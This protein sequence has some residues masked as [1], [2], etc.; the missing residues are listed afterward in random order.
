MHLTPVKLR[1]LYLHYISSI[2]KELKMKTMMKWLASLGVVTTLYAQPVMNNPFNDPFFQDP[3]GDDIFKEMMEMQRQMDELF[4]RMQMRIQQRQQR[5][6]MPLS[7][8]GYAMQSGFVDKGDH[9]ELYT[10]IPESKDN[11]INIKTG[12]GM[13]TIS[14]RIV[15]EEK[16]NNNGFVSTS[17]SEQMMHQ[18]LTLPADADENKI[19]TA[20]ENGMLVVKIGKKPQALKAKSVTTSGKPKVSIQTPA[21]AVSSDMQKSDTQ[22]NDSNVQTN[23]KKKD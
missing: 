11:E 15:H 7:H 23:E 2:I 5:M 21:T 4:N 19:D 3:F 10:H 16:Q 20:F 1:F 13:I 12:N 9:Y 17:R 8:Y 18:A 14:A 22:Q 6:T